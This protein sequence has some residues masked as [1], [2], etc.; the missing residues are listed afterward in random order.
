MCRSVN[1]GATPVRTRVAVVR[2]HGSVIGVNSVVCGYAT[3][4]EGAHIAPGAVVRE[5]TTVGRYSVVGLGAVV[6]KDVPD[7]AIVA[8]NPAR[9]VGSMTDAGPSFSIVR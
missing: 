2:T 1:A 8:G 7:G 9:V 4:Q 3:V 5:G 6:V